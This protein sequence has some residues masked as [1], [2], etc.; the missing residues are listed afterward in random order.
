MNIIDKSTSETDFLN[1]LL[2]NRHI[3]PKNVAD[4]LN[5]FSPKNIPVSHFGVNKNHLS[6]AVTRIELAIKKQEKILIYGDYDVDGITAT[7]ILWQVLYQKEAKV[8]PFVPDRELDGYGIKSDSF[9]KFET[10]NNLKFD[11]LITVDNGIVAHSELQKILDAGTEIIVIDHHIADQKLSKSIITVHST[12]VSG[13]VL[14]WIVAKEIDKNAD[15]GLAALG[16]VTDCL[17][18]NNINRNIVYHGLQALRQNPNCGIKKLIQISGIQPDSISTYDLGFILGPRINAVG[19]LGNPTDA[20][21]LLC[22]CSTIQA[23]KFAQILDNYNKDRQSIQQESID[24]AQ[25]KIEKNKDKVLF[26]ADKSFHPGIIG[27][28]AGR[29]TDKYYLPSIVISMS[30]EVSKGSCRSIKELNIVESL[31]QLSN[32]LIELGGHAGAAGFSIKTKNILKFKKQITQIINQK[33][34]GLNLKQ[35]KLIDAEMKLNAVNLKNCRLI[36]KI[37]P[38]GI[39]NPEPIFLFKK[40]RIVDKRFLGSHQEHLKLKLDDPN[41]PNNENIVA[42]GIAFKKGD[43][44]KNLK[45]GNLIDITAK[46]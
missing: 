31:R 6:Q 26:V 1:I 34:D 42:D 25:K 37:E 23:T 43:L 36:K 12:D 41:T 14:S 28:I 45:V 15:L 9:F 33:L 8:L 39:G 4:F 32:E 13:S 17:P 18:L 40:L 10:K 3:T 29:L 19:R 27:I 7:A 24:L 21:R 2:K 30:D 38:F 16:T 20:L 5:P 22:S 46:L 44:D 35:E 11:L